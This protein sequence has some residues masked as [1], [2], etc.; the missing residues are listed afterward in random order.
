MQCEMVIRKQ[1]LA[2]PYTDKKKEI[3]NLSFFKNFNQKNKSLSISYII[4]NK[5]LILHIAGEIFFFSVT[6]ILG[7]NFAHY[8][9]I[10]I[11]MQIMCLNT[12]LWFKF[13]WP[14]FRMEKS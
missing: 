5:F 2:Q 13:S 14:H 1:W 11:A 7:K 8:V 12:F 6:M 4:L 3:Q 10:S 9:N